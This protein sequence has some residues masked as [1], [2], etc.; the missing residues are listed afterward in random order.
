MKPQQPKTSLYSRIVNRSVNPMHGKF[1]MYSA[2]LVAFLLCIIQFVGDHSLQP[3]ITALMIVGT[4]GA[5]RFHTTD[6]S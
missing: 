4:L 6:K 1:V 3:I 5:T 2:Y